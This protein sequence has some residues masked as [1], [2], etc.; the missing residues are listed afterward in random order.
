MPLGG[1]RNARI[2]NA[3]IIGVAI[4]TAA[5]VAIIGGVHPTTQVLLSAATLLL[6]GATVVLRDKHG[7]RRGWFFAAAAVALAATLL[8]L[9]PLPAALVGVLSP[10]ARQLRGDAALMPLTVDAPATWLALIRLL[11]ATGV[12]LIVANVVETREQARRLLVGVVVIATALGIVAIAQRVLHIDA[13]LGIYRPQS[14]PGFGV[15]GTFVDVNHAASVLALGSLTAIGLAVDRRGSARVACGIAAAITTTALLWTASRGGVVAFGVGAFVLAV[16]LLGRGVGTARAVIVALVLLLGGATVTAWLNEQLRARVAAAPEEL[17]NNQKTRGWL[18]GARVAAAYPWTGVGR[19][20]FE[21]AANQYRAKDEYVRLV[22]PENVVV[23]MTTEWGFPTAAAILA[24]LFFAA[25]RT[26]A[27]IPKLTPAVIGAGAG[28]LAVVLHELVDFGL[29]F[30]GVL[31]PTT[32][33]LGVVATRAAA[34]ERNERTKRS[35]RVPPVWAGAAL[36][37]WALLLCGAAIARTHTLAGD[38]QSLRAEAD[39]GSLDENELHAA[40][41]RHPADDYL[42]LLAA[43][44]ALRHGRA[45]AAMHEINAALSLHPA[46]WQ[47]HRMAAR[48]LAS[49]H[50]PAQAALEYRLAIENGMT[51][52]VAE[53]AAVVG[54]AVVDAVPQEPAPLLEL[55]HDLYNIGR[56]DDAR[57][58]MRRGVDL[59]DESGR[60]GVLADTV[61]QMLALDAGPQILPFAK[62]LSTAATSPRAFT[63]AAQALTAAGDVPA[64]DATM[65]AGFRAHPFDGSLPLAATRL[66]IDRADLTGARTMLARAAKLPLSIAQRQ[67]AE[68]LLAAIDERKGDSEGAALARA[69]AKLLGEQREA[70]AHV[71]TEALTQ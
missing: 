12:L 32:V 62:L 40:M 64:S 22:Y 37:A 54:S 31:M 35:W 60:E 43:E 44:Q 15:F 65:A 34:E 30:P 27:K 51:P 10:A 59:A 63:L 56:R 2:A 58:A 66:H 47:A 36:A 53:M 39:A 67:Q 13:I 46:N 7:L 26:A 61:Q 5:S 24:L 69:R 57:I 71:S 38:W 17:W 33:A 48:L 14:T 6:L 9:L 18:D 1:E 70:G 42:H 41:A 68:E 16:V 4:L 11:A 19:G 52:V 45:N 23:Q 29:E 55:A 25:V 50:R 21:S 3:I 49:M 28:V 20:A 8:Q